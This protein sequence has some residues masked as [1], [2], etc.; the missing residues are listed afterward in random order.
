MPRRR[1]ARGRA[2]ARHARRDRDD[3]GWQMVRSRHLGRRAACRT[4]LS[5]RLQSAAWSG[6][7][8]AMSQTAPIVVAPGKV[9]LDDLAQVLA[10][11]AVVLDP[12][13][14]PRVEKASDIVAK[15][16]RASAPVYGINTGFGKLAST[17]IAAD[18][19]ALLQ[20]NLIVSHCCGVGPPTPEPIVRLMMA[21]K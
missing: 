21:L 19:T 12:S 15:A 8:G 3:R 7:E 17:R 2:C 18:Q 14:W 6:V 20:R 1:D 4:R 10:G 5:D 11:E 9:G 16:A 13:F